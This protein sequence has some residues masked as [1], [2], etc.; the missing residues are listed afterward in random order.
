MLVHLELV[1]KLGREKCLMAFDRFGSRRRNTLVIY[2]YNG[3][4]FQ[5]AANIL[6]DF[7]R[8]VYTRSIDWR[9]I[10]PG[11]PHGGG[12]WERMIEM[13]KRISYSIVGSKRLNDECFQLYLVLW[14]EPSTCSTTTRNTRNSSSE[15][16]TNKT[17]AEAMTRMFR[18]VSETSSEGIHTNASNEVEMAQAF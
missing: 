5:G 17:Q 15:F 1:T 10:P 18:T 7:A 12:V 4:N 9:F 11:T 16:E 6:H 13:S 3:T 2:S 8:R 14:R